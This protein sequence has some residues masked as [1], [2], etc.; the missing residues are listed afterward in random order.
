MWALGFLGMCFSQANEIKKQLI[1]NGYR[2]TSETLG[3]RI[4]ACQSCDVLASK[5]IRQM[6]PDDVRKLVTLSKSAWDKY[7]LPVKSK[8]TQHRILHLHLVNLARSFGIPVVSDGKGGGK[9]TG[10]QQPAAPVLSAVEAMKALAGSLQLVLAEGVDAAPKFNVWT[11]LLASLVKDLVSAVR[12]KLKQVGV[13][14]GSPEPDLPDLVLD[15][16]Q[17]KF[18]R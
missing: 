4:D 8:L 5:D 17:A 9:Q 16:T 14:A 7:T 12:S 18:Q 13:I 6:K 1:A 11:P 10:Q 2:N 3:E 15:I